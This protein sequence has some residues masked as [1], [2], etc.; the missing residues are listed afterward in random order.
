[1]VWKANH[2]RILFE[3]DVK[4]FTN[5]RIASRP[6]RLFVAPIRGRFH[7]PFNPLNQPLRPIF[8][9]RRP[10]LIGLEIAQRG[11]GVEQRVAD[12]FIF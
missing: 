5:K 9:I 7:L 11:A 1:M 12:R 3:Y 8:H 6:I 10:P 2:P 4:P